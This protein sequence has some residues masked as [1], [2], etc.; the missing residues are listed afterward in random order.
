MTVLSTISKFKRDKHTRPIE[1]L[2]DMLVNLNDLSIEI[3]DARRKHDSTENL[4]SFIG[5]ALQLDADLSSWKFLLS[6]LWHY[7]VVDL[8]QH[9]DDGA[10]FPLY[11]DRYHIYNNINIAA[12]WNH[13]RQTLIIVHDMIRSMALRL[14]GVES[15]LESQQM[16]VRSVAIIQEMADDIC[17]SVRYHLAVS[18]TGYGGTIRLPWPLFV[19]GICT[20]AGSATREWII[21]TLDSIGHTTCIQQ[22]IGMSQLLKNG[23]EINILPGSLR[24]E[25]ELDQLY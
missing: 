9:A 19:A 6:P 12:F 13:Y 23:E 2:L 10:Y 22:A 21:Q 24:R 18:Q 7:T 20:G 4:R 8:R 14:W 16:V 17:A 3:H 25:L 5:K 11:G 1:D 15:T